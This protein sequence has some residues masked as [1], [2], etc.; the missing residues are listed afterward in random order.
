[1]KFSSFLFTIILFFVA[2]GKDSSES[3]ERALLTLETA[4][5][6]PQ[7]WTWLA[8][9]N[10][11]SR[12]GDNTGYIANL[13]TNSTK[14]LIYLQ[15]GGACF[16]S[17]TCTSNPSSFGENDAQDLINDRQDALLFDRSATS[18]PFGDWNYAVVPYSTGDV[19][20]GTNNS[21]DVANG[22]TGQNMTGYNNFTVVIEELKNYFNA[23]QGITDIILAG[24]SAGSFGT[25][26]N[27]IQTA[28]AFGSSINITLLAD[29]G[30]LLLDDTLFDDCL[31]TKW[32]DLWNFD[33]P[34]DLIVLYLAT[35]TMTC[36]GFMNIMLLNIR[37]RT[38]D[39]YPP[40][41]IK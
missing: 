33:L 17:L 14:L 11:F 27:F 26:L 41:E 18:N 25:Y 35:M 15:G 8:K 28:E 23:N 37:M 16:N 7:T 2:C 10:M 4:A 19:H 31:N 38:L 22:P 32:N 5:G 21:A 12:N 9:E 1:M 24:G 6:N 34:S 29:S 40:T 30:I 3:P 13:K 39:W 20:S 36:R